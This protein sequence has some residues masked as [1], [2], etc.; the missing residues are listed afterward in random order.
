MFQNFHHINSKS[1]SNTFFPQNAKRPWSNEEL[2]VVKKYYPMEGDAIIE[3]LPGRTIAACQA[4]AYTLGLRKSDVINEKR[5]W[6]AEEDRVLAQ[7][8]PVE[9]IFVARRLPHR[10]KTA[11]ADRIKALKLKRD[12]SG[13]SVYK[14]AEGTRYRRPF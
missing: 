4:K 14:F 10:T 6:T 3:R 8:Y 13:P 5:K 2:G 12:Y 7:F 11:V 1:D 9:G